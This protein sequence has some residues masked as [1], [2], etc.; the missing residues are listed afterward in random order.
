MNKS[1]MVNLVG[2]ITHLYIAKDKAFIGE[3]DK[4]KV[5]LGDFLSIEKRDIEEAFDF[6]IPQC[7]EVLWR[8]VEADQK[9][10]SGEEAITHLN[11]F[12]LPSNTCNILAML[13]RL[14]NSR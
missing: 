7:R 10:Y 1:K 6:L 9:F 12:S 5:Y 8:L 14:V 13:Y 2:R 3:E 11:R 4:A